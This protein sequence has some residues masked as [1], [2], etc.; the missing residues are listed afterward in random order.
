MADTRKKQKGPQGEPIRVSLASN[1][2]PVPSPALGSFNSFL[3]FSP[4]SPSRYP[5]YKD[6]L[7]NLDII[8]CIALFPSAQPP[9]KTPYSL[10][11]SSESQSSSSLLAAETDDIEFESRNQL[12]SSVE[13]VG[14][15]EK[16]YS[17]EYMLGVHNPRTN[18]LTL[19]H[20]PLHLFTPSI[21]SLKPTPESLASRDHQ[22]LMTAQRALLGSTFGTKKAIRALNAQ[23]RNKLNEESF[24]TG[25]VSKGLQNH[26]QSSIQTASASLP[27]SESVE[28]S[29]N[30]ARPIP[31]P[32]FSA[33]TPQQVYSL[34]DIITPSE[35]NSID[36]TPFL[37]APGVK[38]R[39]QLLPY[40]RAQYLW[41]KFKQL[42]PSRSAVE[43]ELPNPS[44]KDRERLKL[45]IHLSYL[46]QFRQSVFPGKPVDR[47]KLVERLN[48]PPPAVI[49]HL[50]ER[51]TEGV[52][53]GGGG[54]Q[55]KVTSF[56]ELK[57]LSYLL[58]LVLR[59]DGYSTDVNSIADDLGMGSKKYVLS[60]SFTLLSLEI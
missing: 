55:R 17:T 51:Y 20:A 1:S 59:V 13:E 53:V 57:L 46:F 58:V 27:T 10:Y 32:N 43:G 47:S 16:G 39:L 56:M 5:H 35:L 11:T 2:N 48:K 24:G 50:I 4:S 6:L 36:L 28:Q 38:E 42:L 30:L 21:K 22:S 29:A 14:G 33:Q 31:P 44:K 34:S 49:D 12:G 9:S 15:E 37:S 60:Y 19:H 52:R 41:T 18:S 26:L 8:H 23:Q 25:S 40:K 3:I 54:E 45:V 7:N